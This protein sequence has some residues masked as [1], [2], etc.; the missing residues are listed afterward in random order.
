MSLDVIKCFVVLR[1]DTLIDTSI[2]QNCTENKAKKNSEDELRTLAY[3]C[4]KYRDLT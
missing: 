2:L 1:I 4:D 3:I